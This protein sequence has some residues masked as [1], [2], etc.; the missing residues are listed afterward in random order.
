M[1][2]QIKKADY[3]S[4]GQVKIVISERSSVQ[5]YNINI[6]LSSNLTNILC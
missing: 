1:G 5:M 4:A 2:T 6:Q 3:C